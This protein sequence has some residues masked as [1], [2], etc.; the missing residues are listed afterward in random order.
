MNNPIPRKPSIIHN[1]MN[2]AI[3]KLSSALHKLGDIVA[4]KNIANDSEG[5]TRLRRVDGVSDG[6]RLFCL[7]ELDK[8]TE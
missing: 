2:L 1:N 6:I 3:P 5:T 4:I 7:D 8:H